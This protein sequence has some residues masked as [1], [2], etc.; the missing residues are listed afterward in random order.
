[1]LVA[2]VPTKTIPM[3][4]GTDSEMIGIPASLANS[5]C[6]SNQ[7][8]RIATTG[9]LFFHVAPFSRWPPTTGSSLSQ[10]YCSQRQQDPA[11]AEGPLE[12]FY[13]RACG[14]LSSVFSG[15]AHCGT[16]RSCN[17][18]KPRACYCCGEA[19][20]RRCTPSNRNKTLER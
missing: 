14:P 3:I 2:L 17:C 8:G 10:Y 4:F 20:R 12:G 11:A 13:N 18:D 1:M 16:L 19:A 5:L 9:H 6:G 7:P 15:T